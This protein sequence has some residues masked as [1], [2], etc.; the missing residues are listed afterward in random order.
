MDR[1]RARKE[2]CSDLELAVL[3]SVITLLR[4]L[5]QN[6]VAIFGSLC[7]ELKFLS[8]EVEDRNIMFLNEGPAAFE[9]ASSLRW[10]WTASSFSIL[11]ISPLSETP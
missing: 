5:L 10:Y 11:S 2:G 4:P 8:I 1:P 9:D 3:G 7:D 6:V